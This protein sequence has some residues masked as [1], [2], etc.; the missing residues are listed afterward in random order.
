[1]QFSVSFPGGT[2]QY[3]LQ[4]SFDSYSKYADEVSCI[5]ITDSNIAGLYPQLFRDKKTIVIPA[6]EA[7]KNLYTIE[8]VIQELLQYEAHRASFIIGAGGGV[9]TDIAG[10]A[11]SVY[12]RGIPFGFIPSTLLGMVDA[13]IGG[14][15]GVDTG[16]YKNVAGSFRQPQFILYDTSL[17]NTL[18]EPEWSNGF[19][20]IIKYAC[21]FDKA[22]FEELWQNDVAYYKSNEAALQA[23]IQRCVN[24]KN[25]TVLADET[26]QKE[27]KLLNFGHTLGHAI[28]NLY[29]LPHG[30]A[31]A[32]GM[33]AACHIAEKVNGLDPKV[34]RQLVALLAQYELPA[35]Y[36]F[37]PERV[38]EVLIRDKKRRAE[39]I[40]YI[41]LE[42]IGKAM[43]QALP[44]EAIKQGLTQLQDAS[45]R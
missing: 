43:I 16:L 5:F 39:H 29:G 32:I 33:V 13:A 26:E 42:D 12:M 41:L 38:M 10:F 30:H 25:K 45:D 4:D 24:W 11:A 28:E 3:L 8:Q 27:R 36:A 1:M 22:L 20:E 37:D 14:K 18:P 15:N 19:A 2:V 44:F 40:D 6:G 35:Y 7:H 21:L 31:V 23:L 9:V 17:L 34:R